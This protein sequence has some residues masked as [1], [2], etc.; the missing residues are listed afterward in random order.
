MHQNINMIG[1]VR[2]HLMYSIYQRSGYTCSLALSGMML[3]RQNTGG[4][5]SSKH[6]QKL[7]TKKGAKNK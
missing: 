4:I 3:C 5:E 7:L 6:M 1:V 2:Q